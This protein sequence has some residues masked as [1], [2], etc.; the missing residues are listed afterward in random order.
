[1][2][3]QGHEG[4]DTDPN[5]FYFD[6]EERCAE[7]IAIVDKLRLARPEDRSATLIKPTAA[8]VDDVVDVDEIEFAE[9][10]DDAAADAAAAAIVAA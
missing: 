8:V 2:V 3:R 7:A 1:L 4:A 5:V 10:D 6:T 9:V